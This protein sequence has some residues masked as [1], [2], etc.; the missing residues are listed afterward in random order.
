MRLP[1]V[2]LSSTLL[3]IF[4]VADSAGE[5]KK[6]LLDPTGEMETFDD[7][8]TPV[9]ENDATSMFSF[10]NIGTSDNYAGSASYDPLSDTIYLTGSTYGPLQGKND[11]SPV[12]S[13]FL[14]SVSGK[15]SAI[16]SSELFSSTDANAGCRAMV[17]YREK[18]LRGANPVL[19]RPL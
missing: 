9:R 2:L 7:D 18:K 13:C 14:L 11:T 6:I 17:H 19:H 3:H 1:I 12:S 16:L 4:A 10:Q 5:G 8:N 15:S